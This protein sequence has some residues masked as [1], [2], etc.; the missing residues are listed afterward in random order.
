MFSKMG[1]FV[2]L[3]PITWLILLMVFLMVV[4]CFGGSVLHL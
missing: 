4:G 3:N 1:C 2:V